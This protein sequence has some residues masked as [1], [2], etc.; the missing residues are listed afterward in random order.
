MAS[1][2]EDFL[3]NRRFGPKQAFETAIENDKR[4]G[5]VRSDFRSK[6]ASVVAMAVW[7]GL[8]QLALDGFLDCDLRE[9][10]FHAYAAIWDNM[11]LAGTAAMKLEDIAKKGND[12]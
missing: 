9:T 8:V 6:E 3:N 1:I 12:L 11:R 4:A 10:M 7:D 2:R 5:R